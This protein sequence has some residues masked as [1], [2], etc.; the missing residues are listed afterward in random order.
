VGG[1]STLRPLLG[2]V[3]APRNRG[4]VTKLRHGGL[5][6]PP[7]LGHQDRAIW[8]LPAR[9]RRGLD[10]AQFKHCCTNATHTAQ[11]CYSWLQTSCALSRKPKWGKK[12]GR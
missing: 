3:S 7:P 4:A 6:Q 9:I 11:A 2:E 5:P 10:R 8:A 12:L 1:E